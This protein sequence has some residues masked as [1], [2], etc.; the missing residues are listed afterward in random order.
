ML[1][2][3]QKKLEDYLETKRAAFPRFYFL[4]NDELLEILANSNNID[5]IQ[6]HL[7]T[8]FDNIKKLK[9]N[10]DNNDCT[11]MCSGEGEEI[12]FFKSPRAKGM[13]EV[14]LS[15]VQDG[16]KETLYKLMKNGNIEY[17]TQDR[18]EWI[19]SHYGQVVACVS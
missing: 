3:I 2:E 5:V 12:P 7:R 16:M 15:T 13:V 10:P 11:H 1:D 8:C 4:S 14:W 6:Q 17:Q 18:K 19:L 9:V